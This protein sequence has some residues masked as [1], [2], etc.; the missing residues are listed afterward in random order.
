MKEAKFIKAKGLYGPTYNE[1]YVNINHIQ[2]ISSYRDII[3]GNI[4]YEIQYEDNKNYNRIAEISKEDYELLEQVIK[5]HDTL[6]NDQTFECPQNILKQALLKGIYYESIGYGNT[7]LGKTIMCLSKAP[8]LKLDYE[9]HSYL[10]FEV[11]GSHNKEKKC[12]PL[13]EY[14]ISW[15]LKKD[16]T[17]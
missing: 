10:C 14:K 2:L 4:H 5:N 1:F 17:E 12:L 13:N 15:W 11:S 3:D 8:K 6:K 7:N 9:T 16:K